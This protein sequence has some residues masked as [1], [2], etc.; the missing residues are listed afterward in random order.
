MGGIDFIPLD[1]WDSSWVVRGQLTI[2]RL[3][4]EVVALSDEFALSMCVLCDGNL[5]RG[6]GRTFP[7]HAATIAVAVRA[8][9]KRGGAGFWGGW[10]FGDLSAT[11]VVAVPVCMDEGWLT[12]LGMVAAAGL[13]MSRWLNE[14]V[15]Q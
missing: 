11:V 1:F 14:L 8:S 10:V 15:Y 13:G 3:F 12:S 9:G 6:G 5:R 2:W 4:L 7:R